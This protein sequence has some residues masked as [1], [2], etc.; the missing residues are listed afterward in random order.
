MGN[1]VEPYVEAL[2]FLSPLAFDVLSF[3]LISRLANPA[4]EKLKEDKVNIADWCAAAHMPFLIRCEFA[5]AQ[6]CTLHERLC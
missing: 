1:M 3:R 5:F 6:L 2:K 4:R